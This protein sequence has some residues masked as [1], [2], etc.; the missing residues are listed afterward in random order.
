MPLYKIYSDHNTR[1]TGFV[2][3]KK[4]KLQSI[5]LYA[6]TWFSGRTWSLTRGTPYLPELNTFTTNVAESKEIHIFRSVVFFSKSCR[7]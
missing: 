1:H 7:F 4:Q 2:P 6:V 5:T 3:S